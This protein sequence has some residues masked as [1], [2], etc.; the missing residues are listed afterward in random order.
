MALSSSL[1]APE[2]AER[3]R[4]LIDVHAGKQQFGV[5]RHA[6]AAGL[7]A[8]GLDA[9]GP[10]IPESPET[11]ALTEAPDLDAK[12]IAETFSLARDAAVRLGRPARDVAELRRW[13]SS[14]G[15]AA[16]ARYFEDNAPAWRARLEL[17]SGYADYQAHPEIA[18]R[19]TSRRRSRS[20]CI[21]R[22]RRS[23][24]SSDMSP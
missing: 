7:D 16:G 8:R 9:L 20:A 10:S 21:A 11:S 5:V 17:D 18:D 4:A 3:H 6:F 2:A 24:G 12:M 22:T 14:L 19:A 13:L 15:I 1:D 23:V